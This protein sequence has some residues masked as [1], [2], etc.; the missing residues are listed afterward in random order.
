MTV[1]YTYIQ[2]HKKGVRI[3]LQG[4]AL[5]R[6]DVSPARPSYRDIEGTKTLVS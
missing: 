6:P 2:R 5:T 4:P 3:W 1:C